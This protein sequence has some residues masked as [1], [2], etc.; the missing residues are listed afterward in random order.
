MSKLLEN[1]FTAFV[2]LKTVSN[3]DVHIK[4]QPQIPRY[5]MSCFAQF[6][7]TCTIFKNVK[8]TH[9]GALLLVK[10]NTPPW[11]FYTF[12]KLYKW[13]QIAQNITYAKIFKYH[14]ANPKLYFL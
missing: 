3:I 11:V 12:F 10:S 5:Y 6:G 9:G 13:Y 1:A 2:H 14:V 8:N 4:P 7:T